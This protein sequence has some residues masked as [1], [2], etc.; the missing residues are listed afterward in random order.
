MTSS[1]LSPAISSVEIAARPRRARRFSQPRFSTK[2]ELITEA[3]ND[4][5]LTGSALLIYLAMVG[6]LW[7]E[8]GK[9]GNR[10][11]CVMTGCATPNHLAKDTGLDWHTV[12]RHLPELE[13]L[14][15]ASFTGKLEGSQGQRIIGIELNHFHA[16]DITET[17][18]HADRTRR[19]ADTNGRHAERTGTNGKSTKTSPYPFSAWRL[20]RVR[21]E[22]EGYGLKPAGEAAGLSRAG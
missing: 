18:R 2:H 16:S 17:R 14:G 7:V 9:G 21:G 15:Y 10:Q 11:G 12:K 5:R 19:H 1:T 4:E 8:P 20:R 22:L 3:L 6:R 13:A